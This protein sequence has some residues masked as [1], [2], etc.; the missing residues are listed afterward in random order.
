MV[1]V[2]KDRYGQVE[3]LGA[4]DTERDAGWYKL[5]AFHVD[6]SE[7]G[8]IKARLGLLDL[9]ADGEQKDRIDHLTQAVLDMLATEKMAGRF[10]SQRDLSTALKAA[11]VKH[12]ASDLAPAL[13]R[14]VDRGAL[15]Y[16]EPQGR[17]K[18]R[19]GWLP[20]GSDSGAESLDSA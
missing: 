8:R 5:G 12:S 18:P 15:I 14:L 10:A 7:D 3:A 6:S 9:A 16:P 11:R 20:S 17:N 1:Y 13:E 4:L 2:V 19:P